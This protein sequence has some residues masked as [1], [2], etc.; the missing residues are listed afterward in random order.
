MTTDSSGQPPTPGPAP[1]TPL[2]VCG[3]REWA[4][5]PQLNVPR[6]KVKI[7]TG[8]RSS[9]L[10]AF[11]LETF[12]EQG[13]EFVRFA[14]HPHQHRDSQ[15]IVATAPILEHR[16]IRS[17]NGEAS[18]RIVIRTA[19]RLMGEEFPVDL[20]LANRDAMGF[21]ML[22]GREALRGRFLVDSNQS[23]LG[24]RLRRSTAKGPSTRRPSS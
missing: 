7:D 3:W 1:T 13:K 23:F 6:I 4:S 22:V 16:M 14:I 12:R 19:L 8:A 2:F 17:S 11:D 24:G 21:R 18:E 20:T 9:A 15:P 10:H 5:L